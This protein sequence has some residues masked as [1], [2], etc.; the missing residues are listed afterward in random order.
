M[1]KVLSHITRSLLV[2][3]SIQYLLSPACSCVSSLAFG[4]PALLLL[5][6]NSYHRGTQKQILDG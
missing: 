1:L 6:N 4:Q 3:I 2:W 5:Q